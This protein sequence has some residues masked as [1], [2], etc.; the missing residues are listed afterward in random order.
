M[1][2]KND[3]SLLRYESIE[4]LYV[5]LQNEDNFI[6]INEKINSPSFNLRLTN[7]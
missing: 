3:E 4:D 5:L 1:T 6:T 2:E 7:N